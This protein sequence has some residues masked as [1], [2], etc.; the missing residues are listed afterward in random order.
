MTELDCASFLVTHLISDGASENASAFS[1]LATLPARYF[2]QPSYY[3]EY[4]TDENYLDI[5]SIIDLD[6]KVAFF[7]PTRPRKP[8]FASFKTPHLLPL[9]VFPI[10][11]GLYHGRYAPCREAHRQCSRIFESR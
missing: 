9:Q 4:E 1:G 2:L 5:P 7:H 8:V 11:V 3:P 6:V 10:I